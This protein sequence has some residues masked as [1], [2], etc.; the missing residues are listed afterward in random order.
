M[1]NDKL[2]AITK[3]HWIGA[4][5]QAIAGQDWAR[6]WP[7]VWHWQGEEEAGTGSQGLCL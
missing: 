1:T 5:A 7:W 3:W 4:K 6:D 2:N